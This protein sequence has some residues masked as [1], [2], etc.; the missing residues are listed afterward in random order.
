MAH[1]GYECQ[2]TYH[3]MQCDSR[4]T[5]VVLRALLHVALVE[6]ER[7]SESHPDDQYPTKTL[8]HPGL[9]PKIQERCTAI[10]MACCIL[11]KKI[12]CR[13]LISAP[14]DKITQGATYTHVINIKPRLVRLI[15]RLKTSPLADIPRGIANPKVI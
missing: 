6:Y 12:H 9:D 13:L 14:F 2:V 7:L 4:A 1:N 10:T 11:L 8:Y 5:A 3:E 15:L